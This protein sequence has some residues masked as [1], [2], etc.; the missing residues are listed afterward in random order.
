MTK[1]IFGEDF[2][3]SEFI[4]TIFEEVLFNII[5]K[6]EKLLYIET[7]FYTCNKIILN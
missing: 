5:T 4:E 7:D 6:S 3:K 1:G 2:K